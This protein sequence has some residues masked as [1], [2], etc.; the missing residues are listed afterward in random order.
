MIYRFIGLRHEIAEI[1]SINRKHHLNWT[2]TLSKKSAIFSLFLSKF[3]SEWF[4]GFFTQILY[5]TVSNCFYILIQKSIS[6]FLKGNQASTGNRD[7]VS[8]GTVRE[9][10]II[11][12]IISF[13]IITI[14]TSLRPGSNIVFLMRR[15]QFI[16][17]STQ[18]C[19][20]RHAFQTSNI[21][22]LN[23]IAGHFRPLTCL[24]YQFYLYC[25]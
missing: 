17:E 24:C 20:V 6:Q 16:F 4:L 14:F 7:K 1:C 2:V 21:V 8:P 3:L 19:F 12:M 25:I 5:K 23:T 11:D 18:I 13:F 22:V 15:I 10:E 9:V